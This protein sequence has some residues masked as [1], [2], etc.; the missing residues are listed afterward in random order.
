[1]YPHYNNKQKIPKK[2]KKKKVPGILTS[3]IWGKALHLGYS[4][5]YLLIC[6]PDLMEILNINF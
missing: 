2:K 5:S 1:M 4:L 3:R 6:L